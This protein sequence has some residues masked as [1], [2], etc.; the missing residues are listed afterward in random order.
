[1]VVEFWKAAAAAASSSSSS[2]SSSHNHKTVEFRVGFSCFLFLYVYR[3]KRKERKHHLVEI[4]H[5]NNRTSQEVQTHQTHTRA[6]THTQY[7][8]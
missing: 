8:L 1:M 4:S 7:F 5:C 6:H 2:S 3:C